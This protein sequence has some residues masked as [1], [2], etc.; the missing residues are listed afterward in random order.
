[1]SEQ[2]G[3]P[4][5]PAPEVAHAAHK[6]WWQRWWGIAGIAVGVLA[7]LNV[8]VGGVQDDGSSPATSEAA[9]DDA[10]A[11]DT[12]ADDSASDDGVVAPEEGDAD[13]AGS[14]T[15]AGEPDAGV[16]AERQSPADQDRAPRSAEDDT[17]DTDDTGRATTSL[18]TGEANAL[19]SAESYLA[20][21][22]FSRSGLIEQLEFEGY[23]SQEATF[24]VDEVEVDW[25]EQAARSAESYLDF[26]AFSRSGLIEQ[27]EFE[28]Y[29]REQAEYGVSQAGF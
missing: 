14:G 23:S 17:D 28:G 13:D 8:V 16:E 7:V 19:R 2:Q 15:G 4:P 25:N 26:S 5:P 22:G 20:F 3:H 12:A 1:M 18:S 27:L 21:S 6:P 10:A 29:T 24:A 9:A 11:S